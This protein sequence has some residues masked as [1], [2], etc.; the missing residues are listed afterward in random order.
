MHKIFISFNHKRNEP[1]ISENMMENEYKEQ[2]KK[3]EDLMN[4]VKE[5]YSVDSAAKSHQP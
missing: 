4:Q 1:L 3:M 2:M 5:G